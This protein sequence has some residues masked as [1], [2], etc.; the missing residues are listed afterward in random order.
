MCNQIGGC[1]GKHPDQC[2]ILSEEYPFGKCEFQ[3]D[4][5][6]GKSRRSAKGNI[7]RLRMSISEKKMSPSGDKTRLMIRYDMAVLRLLESIYGE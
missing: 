5:I 6:D 7:E 3:K 4:D 2:C 1:F